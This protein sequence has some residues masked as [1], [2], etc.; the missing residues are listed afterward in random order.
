MLE[1]YVLDEDKNPVHEPDLIK[2]SKFFSDMKNK[3]VARTVGE[4]TLNGKPV[5]N[6]EISTVFLGINHQVGDGPPLL[7]ETMVF[8]GPMDGHCERC[9][10]WEAAEQQHEKV[11]VKLKL[12]YKKL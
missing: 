3:R 10:T 11:C 7:F 4:V 5:G 1:N 2:F 9:S 8:G 6:V 12:E